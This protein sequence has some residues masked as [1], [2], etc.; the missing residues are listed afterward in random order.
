M[1]KYTISRRNFLKTT[2]A[3]TAAVTLM[4]LGGCNVE[5]TLPP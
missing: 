1:K 5:K 3:T 4:P 2:A